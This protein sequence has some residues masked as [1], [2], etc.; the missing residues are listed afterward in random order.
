MVAKKDDL[1][2]GFVGNTRQI[3][4]HTNEAFNLCPEDHYV[5]VIAL[6]AQFFDYLG[7]GNRSLLL[8]PVV[9]WQDV[10]VRKFDLDDGGLDRIERLDQ[11]GIDIL[12]GYIYEVESIRDSLQTFGRRDIIWR[13]H[14]VNLVTNFRGSFGEVARFWAD[15][16]QN[17]SWQEIEQQPGQLFFG[18]RMREVSGPEPRL[19]S[20]A[21]PSEVRLKVIDSV[22]NS[23]H[24]SRDLLVN[25]C[26][27]LV[28]PCD[29]VINPGYC[30]FEKFDSAQVLKR[31]IQLP[32]RC[33]Q[34]K[35]NVINPEGPL[36]GFTDLVF[37][38]ID[39]WHS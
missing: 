22:V 8:N 16:K 29:L 11:A 12:T 32:K 26:D 23:G 17:A 9:G 13:F 3:C 5:P 34:L 31:Q 30:S 7:R 4:A 39:D 20:I 25:P 35:A 10:I 19:N 2:P 36:A 21:I 18:I 14:V 24:F 37:Y 27:L 38:L 28:N 1:T 6:F 33:I 15:I